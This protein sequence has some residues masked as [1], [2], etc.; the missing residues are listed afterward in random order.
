MEQI[1]KIII[2]NKPESNHKHTHTH[3]KE[4][5]VTKKKNHH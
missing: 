5:R 1:H 2:S 3:T 4:S